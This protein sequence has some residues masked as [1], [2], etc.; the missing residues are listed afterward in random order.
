MILIDFVWFLLICLVGLGEDRP[1]GPLELPRPEGLGLSRAPAAEPGHPALRRQP[2][3]AVGPRAEPRPSGGPG[4]A[5]EGGPAAGELLPL[6]A[7]GGADDIGGFS[8]FRGVMTWKNHEKSSNIFKSHEKTM[9]NMYIHRVARANQWP[10][11]AN[12]S[13][14]LSLSALFYFILLPVEDVAQGAR[15]SDS[16]EFWDDAS[17]VLAALPS[18]LSSLV[19]MVKQQLLA[20]TP[21]VDIDQT[22]LLM[23]YSSFEVESFTRELLARSHFTPILD[24]TD[25]IFMYFH[26]FIGVKQ[27]RLGRSSSS[28]RGST[29]RRPK[30]P[31]SMRWQ[32]TSAP[33]RGASL[34]DVL[35][36][37]CHSE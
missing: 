16:E 37:H 7:P 21:L 5:L 20:D 35:L 22:P 13:L 36:A 10:S 29:W 33:R 31:S 19:R 26:V 6:G 2:P 28:S 34:G 23:S 8:P 24:E 30:V 9:R 25:G 17:A 3:G 11:P 32:R 27:L 12:K 14:F 18:L 15:M 1:L 4:A